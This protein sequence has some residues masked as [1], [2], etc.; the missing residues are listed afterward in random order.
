M[1]TSPDRLHSQSKVLQRSR[2]I[3]SPKFT[4]LV[5]QHIP[6]DQKI[7]NAADCTLTIITKSVMEGLAKPSVHFGAAVQTNR[8][9]FLFREG[10]FGKGKKPWTLDLK[11]EVTEIGLKTESD[12]HRTL[13]V[14]DWQQYG[15]P[16]SWWLDLGDRASADLWA[17]VM[18]EA[19]QALQSAD[20]MIRGSRLSAELDQLRRLQGGND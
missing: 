7:L 11:D 4:G 2:R 13:V 14:I 8:A 9:L 10:T 18:Q 5:D 16:Y 12:I 19:R 6:A 15:T 20:D 1:V 17:T 3:Q